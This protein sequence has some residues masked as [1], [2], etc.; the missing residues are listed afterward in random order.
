MGLAAAACAAS[1][2]AVDISSTVKMDTTIVGGDKDKVEFLKVNNKDQKD[3]DALIFSA[4]IDDKAGGN[5]QFWYRFDGTDGGALYRDETK[6]EAGTSAGSW[7]DG[8]LNAPH[9]VRIRSVNVWFKPISQIKV[10]VGN[11]AMDSYKEQIFWWHG[12][13]GAKPGSWGA[14]GGNYIEGV[15]AKAEITPID[16]LLIEAGIFPGIDTAFLSTAKDYGYKGYGAKVKYNFGVGSATVIFADKG[17]D[18]QKLL[19]VGADFTGV[20]GL[21]AFANFNLNLSKDG[22]AGL[23]LDDYIKYSVDA[24]TVQ[25][26]LPFV[27]YKDGDKFVPG[28]LATVK[29]SYALDAC[30]PY[31]MATTEPDGDAGWVLNDSFS[32]SMTFQPGVTFNVGAAAFDLAARIDVAAPKGADATVTWKVPCAITVGL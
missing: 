22:I 9:G 15:G 11:I 24:F 31:F 26:H 19:G 16:G 18:A 6:A 30:T 10:T 21:Y 17:K 12:V 4:N 2:F 28:I 3:S 13:Y 20:D 23:S 5:F 1:M 27:L 29:V 32:F 14:F 7:E 25:A 8:N